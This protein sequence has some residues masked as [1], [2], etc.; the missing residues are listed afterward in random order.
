MIENLS[1]MPRR[2][3][4]VQ[5]ASLALASLLALA[6]CGED[7]TEGVTSAA[8]SDPAAVAAEPTSAPTATRET[9]TIDRATSTLG[10]TGAKISATHDGS[11]SDFAG[12]IELDPASLTASSVRMTI[13]MASLSIEPERLAT[14]LLTP[15]FFD[16]PQFPT[17]TFESTSVVAGGEG[18][19]QGQPATHTVTGNLTLHGT[20]RTI[21]IPAIVTVEPT[22][23]RAR[24]EFTINRRDF[25]I[26]YPGMP[27][28]LIADG[29][30]IRF[31]VRAPRSAS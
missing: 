7:H 10:F 30:V 2:A 21:A 31:D 17:A 14:H 15:D 5:R 24:S 13:Q 3:P 11:F 28:D 1:P 27:D 6:A 25:A 9:L 26:V 29:V 20:T 4:S 12:T 16:A 19:V 8:V 18:Q 22:G 23:V